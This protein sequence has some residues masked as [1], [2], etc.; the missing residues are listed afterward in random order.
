MLGDV[1]ARQIWLQQLFGI[2]PLSALLDFVDVEPKLHILQLA[3]SSPLWS[4][5]ITP[6]GGRRL[7][8]D[9]K[10]LQSSCYLDRHGRSVA[11]EGLDGRYGD[12]YLIANPETLR[13]CVKSQ[14]PK[15]I[16]N[17]S[18]NMRDEDL[19]IQN[20]EVVKVSRRIGPTKVHAVPYSWRFA[21]TAI[22]GWILLAGLIGVSAFLR[23]TLA[24]AFLALVPLTG[25]V[26]FVLYGRTP[27][28]LLKIAPIKQR[29]F[30]RLVLVAEH[31]NTAEWKVFYGESTILNSL[32]NRP[33]EPE[34]QPLPDKHRQLLR[35]LLRVL[36]L[37]QWSLVVAAAAL[38]DWD[39]LII[40][41]WII[42]SILT[43]EYAIPV[44]KA[45]G[46]WMFNNAAIQMD[47]YQAK[48][49]SR[50]ALLNTVL[51]LNPDT[52]SF[53]PSN[54]DPNEYEVDGS[55][56]A[57][58]ALKW[59]DP[60]LEKVACRTKWEQASLEAMIEFSDSK[61]PFQSPSQGW[62]DRHPDYWAPY[63]TEGI[64]MAAKIRSEAALPAQTLAPG[65]HHKY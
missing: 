53:Q 56:L 31:M 18:A 37:G 54:D 33:L 17:Q 21:T 36:I 1:L 15:I 57:K 9:D 55:K 44:D 24:I 22:L 45:A 63:I 7:L 19:R 43:H 40:T 39:S 25:L 2:L 16:E 35:L 30:T 42:I 10:L 49:S 5:M 4:W 14:I 50:R 32:L 64:Q 58:N 51:A 48:L 65:E 38:Q 60:I 26:V 46:D 12:R 29:R 3:G 23:F 11:L 62:K 59:I 8:T 52:F 61:V 28:K 27:R 13:L 41:S 34:G 47:R 20:L 6:A